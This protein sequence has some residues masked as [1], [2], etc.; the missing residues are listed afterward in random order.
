MA[1]H[2]ASPSRDGSSAKFTISG[3]KRYSNALW[4]EFLE[5]SSSF[6]HFNYDLWFY[7]DHP[8][9][10][11]ALEFDVNQTI[12]GT[13]Y[14][15]GSECNF[16]ADGKWDV[17]NPAR[18]QWEP[19]HVDCPAFSA[20]TW[21]HLL[22]QLERV[23]GQVHY[24]SLTVDGQVFPVDIYMNPQTNWV[25]NEIDVAFQMDGDS[26]QTPYNVWLDQVTLTQ[27]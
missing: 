12:N 26:N 17:W 7:I 5:P 3:S 8:D 16:K 15:W 2:Q 14:T 25:G 23:N 22:W 18:G 1:E 11:Q 4:W 19:S 10:S 13:R 20:A 24:I 27:W 9:V 6:T 21:H